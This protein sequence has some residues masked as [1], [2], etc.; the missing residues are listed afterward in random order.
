MEFL[1]HLAR[2]TVLAL[3]ISNLDASHASLVN[4]SPF[5]PPNHGAVQVKKV[6]ATRQTQRN[7]SFALKGISLIGDK[8]LFS[9]FD[10]RTKKSKWIKAGEPTNGFTIRSYDPSTHTIDFTWNGEEH[11]LK[12]LSSNDTP[13]PL[14]FLPNPTA[15]TSTS[16][17]NNSKRGA[18]VK[19]EHIA[20]PS[21]HYGSTVSIHSTQKI[22]FRE[23]TLSHGGSSN[24]TL[25]NVLNGSDD[26][27]AVTDIPVASLPSESIATKRYSVK[28]KNKVENPNGHRPH[29]LR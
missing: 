27:F 10:L 1:K 6:E 18:T 28:R 24:P 16:E 5:L 29:H 15:S 8:Y 4:N 25:T 13:I 22:Y 7:S 12:L 17:N 2:L 14:E 11:S 20:T 23:Q 3:L 21:Q 26:L 9:I 19:S